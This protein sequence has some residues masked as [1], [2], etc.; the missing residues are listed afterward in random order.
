MATHSVIVL[1]VTSWI[2]LGC[3]YGAIYL[4]VTSDPV[5]LW[6][7]PTSRSRMEKDYFD[8]YFRPFY[9]TEQIFIK[10]VGLQSVSWFLFI[11]QKRSEF[12]KLV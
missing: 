7:S 4:D 1:F 11:T 3:G 8:K 2:I 6:A 10:P 12:P 5:E 9:R